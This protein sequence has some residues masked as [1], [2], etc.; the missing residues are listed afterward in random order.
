MKGTPSGPGIRRSEHL[1]D[2][3]FSE[4]GAFQTWNLAKWAP[5][6]PGIRC[7]EHLLNLEFGETGAF[8]TGNLAKRL[9]DEPGLRMLPD[10]LDEPRLWNII[11][12]LGE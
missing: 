5:S 1:P 12:H 6:G 2:L 7:N 9:L 4:T 8:Q 10:S 3:E 11:G